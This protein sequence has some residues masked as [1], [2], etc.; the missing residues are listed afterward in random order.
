[1]RIIRR[2]KHE[3]HTTKSDFEMGVLASALF[4]HIIKLLFFGLIDKSHVLT[5]FNINIR[6]VYYIYGLYNSILYHIII[7]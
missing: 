3:V 5:M 2:T 4:G 7:F 6:F 1:M